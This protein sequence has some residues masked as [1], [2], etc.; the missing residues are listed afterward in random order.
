VAVDAS[1]RSV[2]LTINS[3]S[4]NRRIENQFIQFW[5][6]FMI[7][8][9]AYAI[10]FCFDSL[11]LLYFLYFYLPKQ[12]GNSVLL[13]RGTKGQIEAMPLLELALS[14]DLLQ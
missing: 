7:N 1:I 4:H 3:R 14:L 2:R 11:F 8:Y 5:L 12:M 13:F 10:P 6:D 9:C